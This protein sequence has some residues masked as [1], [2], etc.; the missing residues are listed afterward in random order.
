VVAAATARVRARLS[1]AHHPY[2]PAAFAALS[3]DPGALVPYEVEELVAAAVLPHCV[4]GWGYLGRA[5]ACLI[6]GDLGATVHLGYYAELRA[7]MCLLATQSIGVLNFRHVVLEQSGLVALVP[8]VPPLPRP[9]SVSNQLPQRVRRIPTHTFV[10]E[11]LNVWVDSPAATGLLDRIIEPGGHPLSAWLDALL[12]GLSN[13][14][15][16]REWFNQW[17]LDLSRLLEDRQSRNAASY[18]PSTFGRPTSSVR[19]A[20]KS[21]DDLWRTFEPASHAFD[22]IDRFILRR[23]LELGY[24][25]ATG[26]R[27]TLN[28]IDFGQ[29]IEHAVNT[30]GPVSPPV[31]DWKT[32][33]LRA[34]PS[35]ELAVLDAAEAQDP[36]GT[37][38]H[39]FQV[40]SRAALLLRLATGAAQDFMR[41]AGLHPRDLAAWSDALGIEMGLW[42]VGGRPSTMADLWLDIDEALVRIAPDSLAG[43]S[44]PLSRHAANS[45]HGQDLVLLGSCERVGLWGLNL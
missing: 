17:G 33:L 32:F 3:A 26:D 13:R 37:P 24:H 45:R 12:P 8:P 39:P 27:H 11:A 23:G 2:T 21:A 36:S 29:R 25:I 16:A 40:L 31:P 14:Q 38:D 20:L 5:L 6:G 28:P 19:S 44:E 10:W 34:S 4:D 1:T 15:V 30:L 42:D 22:F 35:P 7:A 18:H 41:R 43:T 9:P